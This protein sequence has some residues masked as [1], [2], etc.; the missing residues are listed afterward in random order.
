MRATALHPPPPTPITLMRAPLSA[1]FFNFVFQVVESVRNRSSIIPALLQPHDRLRAP[2]DLLK[3]FRAIPQRFRAG[4]A[5]PATFNLAEYI[6]SPAAVVHSGSSKR[7]RPVH[8]FPR[9]ARARLALQDAFR[10]VAQIGQARP[11]PVRKTPPIKARS[12]PTRASSARTNWNSSLARAARIWLMNSRWASRGSRFSGVGSFH[13]HV[14]AQVSGDAPPIL[15]LHL[16]APH[17]SRCTGPARDRAVKWSPQIRTRGG[18]AAWRRR[19][20]PPA[21]WIPRRYRSTRFPRRRFS[22]STAA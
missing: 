16:L 10:H 15:Q 13:Q 21:P 9:A 18:R 4:C 19:G 20:R 8:R 22:G 3:S 14:S 1:F 7:F 2:F 11:P 17:R 5:R 6:A 12:I